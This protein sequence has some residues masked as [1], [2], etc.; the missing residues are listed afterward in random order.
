[1]CESVAAYGSQSEV[2]EGDWMEPV[3]RAGDRVRWAARPPEEG[4]RVSVELR[5]GGRV[6]G[7]WREA[8]TRVVV[9][10]VGAEPIITGRREIRRVLVWVSTAAPD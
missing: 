10:R 7:V 1:M 6:F 3:A 2:V 8:G 4:D 9:A 5:D